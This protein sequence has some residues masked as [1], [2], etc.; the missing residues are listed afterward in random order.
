MQKGR[1]REREK[2]RARENG[3]KERERRGGEKQGGRR[4]G[5]EEKGWRQAD[6][7]SPKLAGSPPGPAS[8]AAG[9]KPQGLSGRGRQP[10]N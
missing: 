10:L 3:G 5:R 8:S 6:K 4:K 2:K 7:K 1:E 9:K